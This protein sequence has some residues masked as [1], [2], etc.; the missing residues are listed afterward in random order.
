MSFGCE[1]SCSSARRVSNFNIYRHIQ[2]D[3]DPLNTF[4]LRAITSSGS[5]GGRGR[6]GDAETIIPPITSFGDTIIHTRP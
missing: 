5:T 2:F 6:S 4:R 3:G 1:R